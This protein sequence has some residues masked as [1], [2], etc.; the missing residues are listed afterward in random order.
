MRIC[1]IWDADYPWDI[2]VEKVVLSLVKAGHS[3]DLVCRN[4]ARRKRIES[5]GDWTIRRLPSLPPILGPLHTLCGFPFPMN[6]VWLKAIGSTI[7]NARA[8]LILVRDLPLAIPC[9]ILG[10]IYR[11]P[12][13]LD[14]AEDYPAMLADSLRYNSIGRLGR[15]VR[16]P[17]IARF[18]EHLT[19]RLVDHIIVV[20]EESRARLT[21]AGV[22]STRLTVVSNTPRIDQW[23]INGLPRNQPLKEE[24]TNLVYLGGLDGVRGIDVA[25]LAIRYLK[26][27][28]HLVDLTVI[29]DGAVAAY[30]SELAR[31]LGVSDRVHF[32]GRLPIHEKTGFAQ[33][34]DIMARSHIGLVPHYVTEH[35]QTTI[36]NKLFDYMVLGLPVIVSDMKSTARIVREENCGDVFRDRD[37]DD[38]ARS[39]L[40]LTNPQIRAQKGANGQAA[41]RR[42]YN[43]S[44]DSKILIQTIEKVK[45][46]KIDSMLLSA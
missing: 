30:L 38:L 45:D 46:G 42:R 4:H 32:V 7:R 18:I 5:N 27:N 22:P 2:R 40:G 34:Q 14:M 37:V 19:V 12:V 39:I 23:E 11:I 41:V 1:K 25:I 17:A 29:G 44:Y 33:V 8:E 21:H 31:K 3:V 28:G 24:R 10:K 43:W 36:S 35:T 26:N 13:V 6:P 20:T 9:A 16:Q 15:M